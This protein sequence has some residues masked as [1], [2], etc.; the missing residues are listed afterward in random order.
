MA[1]MKWQYNLR[2]AFVALTVISVGSA[3]LLVARQNQVFADI[4]LYAIGAAVAGLLFLAALV[5]G[6]AFVVYCLV[7]LLPSLLSRVLGSS[8]KSTTKPDPNLKDPT[9]R[10]TRP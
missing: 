6:P 2:T 8:T 1:Q 9:Q 5:W 3:L 10:P 7:D 4:V